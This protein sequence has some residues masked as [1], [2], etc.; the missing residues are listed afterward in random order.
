MKSK[1]PICGVKVICAGR[2]KKN[3]IR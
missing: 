2:W 3:K 1:N